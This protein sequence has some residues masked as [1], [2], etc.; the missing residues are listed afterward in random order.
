[1]RDPKRIDE[2]CDELK[3]MWHKVPDWRFGQLM[4]NAL[5]AVYQR[6]DRDPFYIEDDQMVEELKKVFDNYFSNANNFYSYVIHT[7]Y[8]MWIG[9][10]KRR[11]K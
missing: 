2:F 7:L 9:N 10:M 5:G 1:M 4:S 11:L 3:K 8:K 6:T